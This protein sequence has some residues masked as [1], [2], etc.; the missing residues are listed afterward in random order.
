MADGGPG[1]RLDP[2]LV[3]DLTGYRSTYIGPATDAIWAVFIAEFAIRILIAMDRVRF[4]RANRLT[5]IA[6]AVPAFRLLRFVAVLRAA[7]LFR[8][9]SLARI[10]T[11]LNRGMRSWRRMLRA[12]RPKFVALFSSVAGVVGAAGISALEHQVNPAL[13]THGDALWWSGMMLI[14]PGSSSWPVTGA[15]R[16][17]PFPLGLY[18]FPVFGYVTAALASIL[19]ERTA[20]G[21]LPGRRGDVA[22]GDA[23]SGSVMDRD[24]Q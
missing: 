6:L 5:V 11:G 17:L 7:A 23:S 21:P 16:I 12:R 13:A 1:L 22:G 10:V 2:L 20:E 4:I 18:A 3:L 24:R 14:T 8:G 15:G 19:V 9:L